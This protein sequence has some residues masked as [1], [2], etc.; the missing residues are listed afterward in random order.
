M[1]PVPLH[2]KNICKIVKCFECNLDVDEVRIKAF[3]SRHALS[4]KTAASCGLKEN[5]FCS[6]T[7]QEK[8]NNECY[9]FWADLDKNASDSECFVSDGWEGKVRIGHCKITGDSVRVEPLQPGENSGQPKACI[10]HFVLRE[11]YRA[12]L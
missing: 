7:C 3:H 12:Y 6:K 10:E 4:P 1:Q 9:A 11:K 8:S 5:V 2:E